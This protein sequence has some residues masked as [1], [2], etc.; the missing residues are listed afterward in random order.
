MITTIANNKGGVGK[1]TLTQNIAIEYS[2]HNKKVL[3]IDLDNQCNLTLLFNCL[4]KP[5]T[6]NH[7]INGIVPI[8]QAIYKT[9]QKNIDIIC[10]NESLDISDSMILNKLLQPIKANYDLI[11]ID[12]P[13][14]KEEITDIALLSSDNVLIP[15]HA[16]IFSIQGLSHEQEQITKIRQYNPN[17]YIRGLVLMEYT[18]R[19]FL[20]RELE[21][22]I[23]EIAQILNTKVY[24]TTI[25]PSVSVPK[26]Q[27][28]LTS[29]LIENPKSNVSDD[30]KNLYK[31]LIK[32]E[33]GNS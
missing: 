24:K 18:H 10:G 14:T 13:P 9:Q 32:D 25:R 4:D 29:V 20:N 28:S 26:A 30:F 31:E 21:S 16:D 22:Q 7:L 1:T 27:A 19:Y 33:K 11:L 15:L 5:Y 23:K 6:I 8:D 2:L 17:L 3:I 12:T